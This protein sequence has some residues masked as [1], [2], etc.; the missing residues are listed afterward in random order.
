MAWVGRD[1]DIQSALG[2][3]ARQ[4]R[5]RGG[6]VHHAE[7]WVCFEAAFGGTGLQRERLRSQENFRVVLG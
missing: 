4:C 6:Q 5:D 7:R 2:C 3:L 1:L